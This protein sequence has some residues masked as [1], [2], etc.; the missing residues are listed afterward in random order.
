MR[1]DG[2]ED[3]DGHG[4]SP[5]EDIEATLHLPLRARSHDG[6]LIGQTV[7]HYRI[8]REL[9][10]GGM[11]VVYEAEDTKLKRTVALKFLP[12]ETTSDP[13]A[14]AR[15]MHEAQ[16]ASALDHVNVCTIHEINETEDGQ[17]FLAMARYEGRTLKERIAE[18]PL[19][20]AEA[21]DITRQ[22]AEGLAKAHERDIIH[23]DIKPANIFIT[24]DGPVKILDFGL[25]KLSGQ[26]QITKIGA[27]LGTVAYMSIEQIHGQRIDR[28]TDIWSLGV[29]LYE[30]LAGQ[31]P[32]KGDHGQAVIYSI[33]HDDAPS[34]SGLRPDVPEGCEKII[35]RAM[36]KS[37]DDRY[38]DIS[39][40]V[41]D[42]GELLQLLSTTSE[43]PRGRRVLSRP[44]RRKR[45]LIAAG[46]TVAAIVLTSITTHLLMDKLAD[47]A[48]A[49]AVIPLARLAG[50]SEIEQ[51]TLLIARMLTTDLGESSHIRVLGPA[52]LRHI[53]KN[54]QLLETSEFTTEDFRNIAQSANLS[55]IVTL[56]FF[57]GGTT[58]RT[59][60]EILDMSDGQAVA[61]GSE[62]I[63]GE[64]N[65]IRMIDPLATKTREALLS[66]EQLTSEQDRPFGDITSDSYLAITLFYRG[67]EYESQANDLRAVE[68]YNQ[69]LEHDPDFVL[70]KVRRAVCDGGNATSLEIAEEERLSEYE[71]LLIASQNA[72]AAGDYARTLTLANE[73]LGLRQ[74]DWLGLNAKYVA[75]YFLG[76]YT[77][78]IESCEL[79]IRNGYRGYSEHLILNSAYVMSGLST[80][81]IVERY[82]SYL[83]QDPSDV[84]MKFWL[85]MS[86]L[87][88]NRDSEA[89]DLLDVVFQLYPDNDTLLKVAADTYTWRNSPD[90][91]ADYELAL[92]YL[93]QLQKLHMAHR[94]HGE[95]QQ[96][97]A[98]DYDWLYNGVPISFTMGDIY[99]LQGNLDRAT[100]A[101]E[102]S[103]EL[104]P[105]HYNAFYRLGL[106]NDQLGEQA[107]AIDYFER[108][109]GVTDFNYYDSSAA[110]RERG[111]AVTTAC[112][113]ISRPVALDD[114]RLRLERL[115]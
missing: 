91:S 105:D 71:R 32:F 111:C 67:M 45:A 35:V 16:A 44:A 29:T 72:F 83:E 75:E 97:N 99:F 108:Y 94:D 74:S 49:I 53:L 47:E 54:Q 19:P 61:R 22:I 59:D 41:D 103:L 43:F 89:Q 100:T 106:A 52:A 14:K 58:L 88:L 115:R 87:V 80:E 5:S 110:G 25:A 27:T 28:T 109:V 62:E 96:V 65:L 39:A 112:H 7:S 4:Q 40:M 92:T 50:D 85:A 66:S 104:A 9:G 34:I 95:D 18:G 37:P 90:K 76:R 36:E 12:P 63:V 23:R 102:W 15:F 77:Q 11:G 98:E 64:E 3:P 31:Q 114:A 17:L 2:L 48:P 81:Q 1:D 6:D 13:E 60:I 57:R 8:L 93:Y 30:M 20:V 68:L 113:S 82:R 79:A 42:L 24:G 55:H 33:L 86:Y 51:L 69:A 46:L 56:S 73:M 10:A 78:T 70:A 26:T 107:K 101:Y 38:Q 21:L 84:M